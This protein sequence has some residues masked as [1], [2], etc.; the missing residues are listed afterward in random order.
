MSGAGD[1]S[2]P[3]CRG[4]IY[5]S[6]IPRDM[7]P[8]EVR[9]YFQQFGEI[10]RQKFIPVPNT[11]KGTKRAIQFAEG[12]LEFVESSRA[13]EASETMNGSPVVVKKKRRAFGEVWNCKYL[14][15][16]TWEDLSN[17]TEAHRREH[18]QRRFE[19]LQKERKLNEGFRRK[20]M[21]ARRAREASYQA[22]KKTFGG[23]AA[24]EPASADD[25]PGRKRGR[26]PGNV[27]PVHRKFTKA[28]ATESE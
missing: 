2:L 7:M 18:K 10:F 5:L 13:K 4:V 17:E 27:A 24:D 9:M 23:S 1:R 15:N 19:M 14:P 26:S 6:S 3:S 21:E 22:R 8:G 20:V 25:T 11:G 16:F 28:P 12:W